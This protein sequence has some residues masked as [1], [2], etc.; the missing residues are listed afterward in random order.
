MVQ[1]EMLSSIESLLREDDQSNHDEEINAKKRMIPFASIHGL[2][3]R[4][5]EYDHYQRYYREDIFEK[6]FQDDFMIEITLRLARVFDQLN[7]TYYKKISKKDNLDNM[8]AQMQLARE[9]SILDPWIQREMGENKTL[10]FSTIYD[11]Y[12][13]IIYHKINDQNRLQVI[14]N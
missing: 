7:F 8:M 5:K 4:F 11:K 6:Y 14:K 13:K 1:E 3:K 10:K 12:E 9:L 2:Y